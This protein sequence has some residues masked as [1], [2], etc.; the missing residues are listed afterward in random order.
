MLNGQ[1]TLTKFDVD[2]IVFV[3]KDIKIHD[4]MDYDSYNVE[5]LNWREH[6]EMHEMCDFA[7]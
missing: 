4:E 7:L 2:G 5:L 6:M 1:L 3:K